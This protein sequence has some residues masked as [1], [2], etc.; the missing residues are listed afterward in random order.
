MGFAPIQDRTAELRSVAKLFEEQ[1]ACKSSGQ[2]QVETSVAVRHEL[3]RVARN[4]CSDGAGTTR[5]ARSRQSGFAVCA[6][7]IGGRIHETSTKLAQLTRL[8]RGRSLF[9]DRSEEIE[10]LTLQ[11]K[12]D[13]GDLN[14]RLDELQQLARRNADQR[15]GN[16]RS[17]GDKRTSAANSDTD[18]LAQQHTRIIVDSLKT[19]LLNATQAFQTVL[20]QRSEDLR[21]QQGRKP[22]MQQPPTVP[23]SIFDLKPTEIER[24][25]DMIDLGSGSL[26]ASQHQVQ[27]LM[28]ATPASSLQYYQQRTDAVQRVE[29]TIVELGQIF[30]QLAHM[31]AEQGELVQRIDVNIEDSLAQV[32]GAHGQLLRYFDSLRSNRGLI[33]KLFGV[34]SLFIL[35][36]VLVL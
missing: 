24:G 3:E 1:L 36:W 5:V 34:L 33:M 23:R 27:Q 12:E 17:S 26:G 4:E 11:I 25:A 22:P 31:V 6:A 8:A 14:R 20:Q 16:E 21:A 28:Q 18:A 13:I 29:T 35:L 7:H 10:R 2:S 30:H 9:D 19:R 32:H 15:A